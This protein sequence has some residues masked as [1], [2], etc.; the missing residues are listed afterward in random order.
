MAIAIHVRGD[1]CTMPKRRTK[2]KEWR[3]FEIAVSVLEALLRPEGYILK[4]PDKLVDRDT[5]ELREVDCSIR[6][7]ASNAIISLECRRRGKKQDVCWIEQLA[8]K[9]EALGLAGTIAVSS[10]GFFRP[11]VIK[12]KT[13]GVGLRTFRNISEPDV[14]NE[15]RR[16]LQIRQIT[17]SAKLLQF[18]FETQDDPLESVEG[19][20]AHF[21]AAIEKGLGEAPILVNQVTSKIICVEELLDACLARARSLSPGS[22]QRKFLLKFPKNTVALGS[23]PITVYL[24]AANLTVEIVVTKRILEGVELRQ[25]SNEQ[26]VLL[27]VASADTD[28]TRNG[29]VNLQVVFT[30]AGGTG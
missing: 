27:E 17:R 14:L 18:D 1:I 25:Y 8:C 29:R 26:K 10:T 24:V 22:N 30:R 21:Q 4:S 15:F 23:I 11:A 16:D 3:K 2:P 6:E 20:L 19:F 12:A 5:G 28:T 7:L 13:R 9:K